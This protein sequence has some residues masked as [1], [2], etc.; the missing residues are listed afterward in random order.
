MSLGA[1]VWKQIVPGWAAIPRRKLP[2]AAPIAP[3]DRAKD[4]VLSLTHELFFPSPTV[5]RTSILLA[6]ADARSKASSISENVAVALSQLT[7]ETVAI[8]E[9]SSPSEQN[10]WQGKARPTAFGQGLWQVYS[11]RIADR[12]WQIPA[13][14]I[15]SAP[16]QDRGSAHDG[17]KE[18][19]NSFD[20]FLLSAAVNDSELQNLCNL[21]DAAVLVLTANVTRREAALR[22]QQELLRRRVTLLGT[23]FDQITRPIPES[24][25]RRL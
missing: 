13:A 18:L 7:G 4:P 11:S 16:S 15:G 19:R 8:V 2:I 14:L 22:A 1:Q 10:P 23:V 24:I 25:Y 5:R 17:L 6:A 3:S 21:C 9:T 12:V 20:Y